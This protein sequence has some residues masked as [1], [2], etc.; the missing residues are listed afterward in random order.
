MPIARLLKLSLRDY[1]GHLCAK[2]YLSGCNFR[3][4]Y[5]P[6]PDVVFNHAISRRVSERDVL[7]HLYRTKGVT[8]GV[9]LGGGEPTLHNGL[10]GFTFR[11]KSVGVDVK[12]DTNGTRPKRVNKL[13]E[14]GL[15]DYVSMDVK[16]PLERYINVV[17]SKVDVDAVRQSIKLLRRGGVDYEFRTTVIPELLDGNDLEKM[18]QSL[19][20]SKRFALEQYRPS[21]SPSC[22]QPEGLYS[23]NELR[24]FRDRIAPYFGECILRL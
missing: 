18:A 11:V 17:K 15:L 8:D 1:P 13:M 14:E 16:A 12:L 9:C 22:Q 21:A 20:G 2:V 7:D 10:L 3:C 23:S 4:P 19:I 24:D 6:D 5:C